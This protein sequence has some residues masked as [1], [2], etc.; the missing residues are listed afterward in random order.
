MNAGAPQRISQD[1]FL[2]SVDAFHQK[3]KS[4][5]IAEKDVLEFH[6]IISNGTTAGSQKVIFAVQEL[7]KALSPNEVVFQSIA[8]EVQSKISTIDAALARFLEEQKNHLDQVKRK[9]KTSGSR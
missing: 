4:G 2:D 8:K 5:K 1:Q 3:C 7:K 9:E 6:K